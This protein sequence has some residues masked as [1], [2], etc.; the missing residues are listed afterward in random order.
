[1]NAKNS[2]FLHEILNPN[3]VAIYGANNSGASLACIQLMNLIISEYSGKIYP[4]HLKLKSIMGYKAYKSISELPETP[5]VVIIVLPPQV[6]PQIFKECGEKGV[7]YIILI[8]GGFRELIGDRNNDLTE[9]INDTARE[10]GIRFIGPN[11]LGVFNNWISEQ[12][13]KAFNISIW[14]RLK[15]NKFSIASQSGTLSSHIY[16]DPENLDLGLGKSISVGNEANIDL[17]DCLEYYKDDE[18]TKVI[19]LYIEEIKRGREFLEL[20]KKITIKKPIIAIYGGGSEAGN[21]ALS[22]H[23]GSIAGNKKIYHALFKETGIIET[24]HV[25]EFLD[26]AQA[27]VKGFLPRGNRIGIIT[28]SGGPG[29]MLANNAERSGLIVPELSEELQQ[30]LKTMLPPMASFKNPIDVTFDMNLPYYYITLPEILMKSGEI[31]VLI[32]YGVVGFQDVMDNYLKKEKI[33]NHAEFKEQD[34]VQS[35]ALA[36]KLVQ[37]TIENAKKYS[38]PIF[39]ISPQNFNSPWSKRLRQNGAI[40]FRFWDR[41]IPLIKKL[42]DYSEFKCKYGRDL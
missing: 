1:M 30:E 29:T 26:I 25:Q 31:D 4:I 38:V 40:L 33:K 7:K 28:N 14:E 18:Q 15:R 42:C 19:G 37:P 20:A 32:Q 17:V 27:L 36:K 22:S 5:E 3:I 8:S 10:Y 13:G 23:T 21:R 41:P 35:D 39:H 16:F 2:H 11:C 12:E 34:P 24:Y 6:V 9:Q